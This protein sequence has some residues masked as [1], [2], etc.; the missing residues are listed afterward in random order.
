MGT[1]IYVRSQQLHSSIFYLIE[2]LNKM[3]E[4]NQ[5]NSYQCFFIQKYSIFNKIFARNSLLFKF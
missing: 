5:M 4:I 1:T 3:K 2:N